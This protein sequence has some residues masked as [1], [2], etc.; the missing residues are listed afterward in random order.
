MVLNTSMPGLQ[1]RAA[2]RGWSAGG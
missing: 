2:Q 1:Q